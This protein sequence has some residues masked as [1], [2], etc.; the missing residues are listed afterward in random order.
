M[1][2]PR[3]VAQGGCFGVSLTRRH[4]SLKSVFSLTDFFLSPKIE[5]EPLALKAVFHSL[6]RDRGFHPPRL[7]VTITPATMFCIP[8]LAGL[9]GR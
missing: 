5:V 6:H 3:A 4:L 1:P 8:W 2:R 7:S 9:L